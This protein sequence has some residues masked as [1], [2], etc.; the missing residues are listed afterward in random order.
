MCSLHTFLA[1]FVPYLLTCTCLFL[2]IFTY[3]YLLFLSPE[4]FGRKVS[5]SK[6]KA[7]SALSLPLCSLLS[8]SPG[9]LSATSALLGSVR[10]RTQPLYGL[11][12]AVP[13]HRTGPS[14]CG[15]AQYAV[16]LPLTPP[17]LVPPAAPYQP[18]PTLQS[19]LRY[20]PN[21]TT[22]PSLSAV[23]PPP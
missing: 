3:F 1:S 16:P 12:N 22:P 17:S 4:F 6:H 19:P 8:A 14:F 5:E 9:H 20:P 23:S 13:T 10:C 15:L 21:N 7:L 18:T 2:L 11:C